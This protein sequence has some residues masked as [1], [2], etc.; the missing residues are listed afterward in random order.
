[1]SGPPD[2][3]ASSV[4]TAGYEDGLGRRSVRF[5]REVGGM[6]EC[7]HLRPQ[8]AVFEAALRARA[9]ALG[10]LEDERFAVVR[11]FEK[12]ATGL[13]VISDLVAGQRLID[14]LE[15]RSDEA[16]VSGIDAAFGFLLQAMPALAQLHAHSITHGA[17]AP[18][19]I[20]ITPNSQVV[21]LD[22]I[23]GAA[24]DRLTPTRQTL[25]TSFGV[26]VAP[27]SGFLSLDR[28]V[29]VSQV[30]L[31][32]LLLALG[33]PLDQNASVASLVPLVREIAE[34]A[35]IRAG[36]NFAE[37]VG[38]FFIDALPAVGKRRTLEADEAA[39]VIRRLLTH[40]S[41]DESLNALAELVSYRPVP[42]G[43]RAASP[44]EVE[45]PRTAI[46]SKVVVPPAPID[47][48]PPVAPVPVAEPTPPPVPEPAVPAP[49]PAPVAPATSF[50]QYTPQAPPVEPEHPPSVPEPV[51]TPLA[52]VAVWTPPAAV[53]AWPPPVLVPPPSVAVQAPPVPVQPTFVAVQPP[54]VPVGPPLLSGPVIPPLHIV[55][56]APVS[57]LKIRQA[58][59]AGYAPIRIKESERA[60][61]AEPTARA[62]AFLDRAAEQGGGFPWKIA[63]A[64]VLV[65]LVGAAA[66]RD[67]LL[68][69]TDAAPAEQVATPA[70]A[71][72]A[73]STTTGGLVIDSQPSGAKVTLDG[74]EVGTTPLTLEAIKPGRHQVTVTSGSALVQRSIR[75]EAGKQSTINVPV[76]SGWVAIFA[77][78]RLEVSAGRRSLG[79]T[80][81]RRILL[82]P[83]KH[84]LTLSSAEFGYTGTETVEISPGEERVLNL[85]PTG[86]VNLNASPWAEV[87]IDG[88]RAGETPLANLAVPLGTR[89]FVFKN[90]Q[91]GERKLTAVVTTTT[92]A[93]S[94]DFGRPPSKP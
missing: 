37:G 3:S 74:K 7:L 33:R 52:P 88:K 31:C 60:P 83:G 5:N 54:R 50:T 13:R 73:A 81:D 90:P 30:T 86:S 6:L 51:W 26:M 1:M 40:I 18:G 80:E 28:H 70:P 69:G 16:A 91:Y 79:S 29:D 66:G 9:E 41:E 72:V 15:S 42:V 22:N 76:F 21:L 10:R 46:P 55:P 14:V 68:G 12:D 38:R 82:P 71:P 47:T 35:E 59:P 85:Q 92:S 89:E 53:P 93:L 62:L 75:I 77:P 23:Y 25:W 34:L 32:A 61:E 17:V 57:D 36:A 78:I 67:Y 2:I 48:P 44:I 56:Q 63:A 58:G 24:L 8:F 39:V 43:P 94:V 87:W 20:I 11:D 84:V 19:R 45:R 64:A 27:V 65:L 49:A 4:S